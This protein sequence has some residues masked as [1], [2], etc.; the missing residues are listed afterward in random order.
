[1]PPNPLFRFEKDEFV[2]D[3][4]LSAGAEL[5]VAHLHECVNAAALPSGVGSGLIKTRY[6]RSVSLASNVPS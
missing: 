4:D 5:S 2:T 6:A 3:A 1:M